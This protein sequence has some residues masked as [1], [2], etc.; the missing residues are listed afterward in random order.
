MGEEDPSDA[1]FATPA[2]GSAPHFLPLLL[3][4]L[5]GIAL[6]PITFRGVVPS[7]TAVMAGDVPLVCAPIGD[8]IAQHQAGNIRIIAS[9]GSSRSP[10]APDIPT[11]SELGY[12]IRASSWFGLFAPAGTPKSM[13]DNFNSIAVSALRSDATVARLKPLFLSVTGTTPAA[14]GAIMKAD[15]ELW[16]PIIKAT[17]FTGK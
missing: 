8:Q 13:I 11:L 1:N 12:K 15:F 9:S 4:T 3:G 16:A 2:L 6:Q 5:A 7:I 14:L 10:F 17:G